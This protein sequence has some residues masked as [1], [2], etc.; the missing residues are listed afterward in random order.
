MRT[1]GFLERGLPVFH[2]EPGRDYGRSSGA[3][4]RPPESQEA[5]NPSELV[6]SRRHSIKHL[7]LETAPPASPVAAATEC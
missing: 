7:E 4:P 3:L 6:M 5:H 1:K 2:V